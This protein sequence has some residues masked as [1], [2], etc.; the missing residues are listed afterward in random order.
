M[1]STRR[2][3][4]WKARHS[5]TTGTINAGG[6]ALAAAVLG[7]AAHMPP[8][9][10]V[11]VGV[12]GA[13]GTYVSGMWQRKLG[14]T[15][16]YRS[17]LW[18]AAGGWTSWS[19]ATTPWSWTSLGALSAGLVLA[20]TTWPAMGRWEDAE[21]S[22]RRIAI[23]NR[24]KNELGAEWVGRLERVCRIEGAKF[25]GL[26]FWD[27]DN[28][29]TV[30]MELPLGGTTWTDVQM[31]QDSLAADLRLPDG[32][33]VE[34]AKGVN[35]GRVI[36]RVTTVDIMSEEIPYPEDY[37]PRSMN[38]MLRFGVHRD[39][40]LAEGS[41]LDDCGILIGTTGGGKTNQVNVTNAELLMTVDCL[42]WHIDITG[43]G[44][45]LPWLRTWALDGTVENPVIDWVAATVEEAVVMLVMAKQIIERRKQ[46][47][48]DLMHDVDD[49][50][51]PVSP[52]LPEILIVADEAAQLPDSVQELMDDVINTGRAA[53]VRL[54]SC[55]LRATLDTIT[56]PMKK[57]A[58]LRIG[59]HTND[60]EEWAHLFAGYQKLELEDAPV[61]GSGFLAFSRPNPRP[62]KGYRLKPKRIDEIA[63]AVADRRPVLDQPS[64]TVDAGPLYVTRW[65]RVLPKLY[66]G[67]E[68]SDK[69]RVYASG[70]AMVDEAVRLDDPTIHDQDLDALFKQV[71]SEGGI[72]I[73]GD[74]PFTTTTPAAASGG[75]AGGPEPVGSGSGAP[76]DPSD[77]DTWPEDPDDPRWAELTK[78]A[79]T[80]S[81]HPLGENVISLNSRRRGGTEPDD[82]DQEQPATAVPE[83]PDTTPPPA[84]EAP[85][86][87]ER[88]APKKFALAPKEFAL[89]FLHAKGTD[90]SGA[91]EISATLK[92]AGYTTTRQTAS[93]WLKEWQAT[94][95]VVKNENV[96]PVRYVHKD[97]APK[98]PGGSS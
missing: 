90:G 88:T 84:A 72:D 15:L 31:H 33:G 86:A 23:I 52:G 49:D 13:M 98:L 79:P 67:R 63:L 12:T 10:A 62:F 47:Y 29:Y 38:Q 56:A 21:V 92:A 66:A 76:F 36:L 97:H 16:T 71:L 19:I 1:G 3:W 78:D 74:D 2:V 54:L 73:D 22:R 44:I 5:L 26:T 64:L 77:P 81:D 51:I 28:G 43:A 11:G 87:A 18:L 75:K 6:G 60:A 80:A 45:S 25:A 40:T 30:D 96:S 95:T 27:A 32:C 58:K 89:D 41:L 14:G 59:M 7:N 68:L 65:A 34:V 83:K 50:K 39:G 20:A 85:S 35:R 4:D 61:P 69:A 82:G 48:Q 93:D 53:R 17:S 9:W 91:S 55:A 8:L 24:K 46:A 94:G 70:S 42:V 57:H 37:A